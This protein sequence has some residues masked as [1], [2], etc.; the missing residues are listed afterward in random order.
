MDHVLSNGCAVAYECIHN[1]CRLKCQEKSWKSYGKM[2]VLILIP[3]SVP[4]TLDLFWRLMSN[5]TSDEIFLEWLAISGSV[6]HRWYFLLVSHIAFTIC[7]LGPPSGQVMRINFSKNLV[8]WCRASWV[9]GPIDRYSPVVSWHQE[10]HLA[11]SCSIDCPLWN[12][13]GAWSSK[14]GAWSLRNNWKSRLD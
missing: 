9:W 4:C 6:H 3:S 10:A 5:C 2:E 12:T 11:V 8:L 7:R 1:G 13:I 14:I